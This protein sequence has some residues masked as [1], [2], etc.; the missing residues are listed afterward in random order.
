[1]TGAKQFGFL[2]LR[3]F[4]GYFCA[5][6]I[7]SVSIFFLSV[8]MTMGQAPLAGRSSWDE[9]ANMAGWMPLYFFA[10]GIFAAPVA[11]VGILISELAKI[12]RLWFFLLIGASAPLPLLF[13]GLERAWA[14]MFEG[15]LNFAPVGILAAAA[16]WLVRHRK[17]PI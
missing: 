17:W 2:A 6:F 13:G 7:A 5:C 14:N 16:F 15:F 12:T 3:I 10:A 11:L 4:L 9:L 8:F 1:M